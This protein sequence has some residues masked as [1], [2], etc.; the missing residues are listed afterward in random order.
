MNSELNMDSGGIESQKN[1]GTRMEEAINFSGHVDDMY[2][3]VC[4]IRYIKVKVI[5]M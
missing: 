1:N 3:T 2:M 4:M 5:S